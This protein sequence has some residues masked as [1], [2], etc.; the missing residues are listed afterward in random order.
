MQLVGIGPMRPI[1]R[2]GPMRYIP[3]TSQRGVP[4]TEERTPTGFRFN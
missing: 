4:D 1:G 2:I 3:T